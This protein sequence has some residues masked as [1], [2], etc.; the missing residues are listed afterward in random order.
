M[1]KG[2]IIIKF[3]VSLYLFQYLDI[4]M[5]AQTLPVSPSFPSCEAPQGALKVEHKN[6]THG[7]PGDI[8]AYYGTDAVFTLTSTSLAQCLCSTDGKGIQ[9]NWWKISS[10]SFNEIES[11]KKLG[12]VY[13]PDG[14]AW[15]LDP[16][17]FMAQ[18]SYYNCSNGD[19][20]DDDDNEDKDKDDNK[21]KKDSKSQKRIGGVGEVLGTSTGI[22]DVLGLAA[23]GNLVELV[24]LASLMVSSLG[25][26]TYYATKKK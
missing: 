23:T 25:V 2:S 19:H 18:S 21:D 10:L 24:G 11:L 13:V 14:S 17:P 15:G 8:T 16:A 12:W 9:T 26:M 4:P 5:S 20:D 7:V 3:I 1:N 6:G 22:G